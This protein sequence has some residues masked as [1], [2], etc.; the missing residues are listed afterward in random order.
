MR[1]DFQGSASVIG[2]LFCRSPTNPPSV[3]YF[4]CRYDGPESLKARTILHSLIR[5]CL[6]ADSMS[7]QIE[8]HLKRLLEDSPPDFEELSDLM[9][10]VS[11][12]S[13]EQFIVIDAI[14]ECKKGER[15]ELLSALRR[16][17]D[18]SRVKTKI[19]LASGPHIGIEL[20]KALKISYRVSMTSPAVHSDI[21]TY[22]ES[23][24]GKKRDSGELV[25]GQTQLITEIQD[26][27]IRGAQGM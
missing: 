2:E 5:Q 7:N 15:G 16:L 22:I 17:M 18:S 4:F 21:K 23:V 19:F 10:N 25:V 13:Q 24:I 6:N 26:A 27:L 8:A 20:K 12:A 14:D 3:G 9:E 11:A 1:T